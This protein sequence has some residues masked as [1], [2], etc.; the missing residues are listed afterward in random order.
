[1]FNEKVDCGIQ[2]TDIESECVENWRKINGKYTIVSLMF[3]TL[4]F[5]AAEK[6]FEGYFK[7]NI[8]ILDKTM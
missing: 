6:I 1:M 3:A 5:F 7:G 8:A 2:A 4:P